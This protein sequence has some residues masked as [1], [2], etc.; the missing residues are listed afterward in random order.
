M[1][2]TAHSPGTP[3]DKELTRGTLARMLHKQG[4][5][6]EWLDYGG[7]AGANYSS[8]KDVVRNAADTGHMYHGTMAGPNSMLAGLIREGTFNPKPDAMKVNV[9]EMASGVPETGFQTSVAVPDSHFSRGTGRPD[10]MPGLKTRDTNM[11]TNEGAPF[12]KWFREEVAEPLGIEAVPAQGRMWGALSKITGVKTAI[13]KT[14]LEI[15]VDNILRRAKETGKKPEEILRG[16]I[17][18]TEFAANPA[19]AAPLSLAGTQER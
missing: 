7:Q 6:E 1:F 9:Y 5:G 17:R 14:K 10:V 11:K 19:Q 4:R 12:T 15:L 3:V 13:G 8:I 18:G 16:V 2:T